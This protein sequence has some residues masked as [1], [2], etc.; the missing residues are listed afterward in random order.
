MGLLLIVLGIVIWL[1]LS[2][3]VGLILVVVGILLLFI[4]GPFYGYGWYRGR[5]GPP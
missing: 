1:L 5:R 3:L 4:P 2:P